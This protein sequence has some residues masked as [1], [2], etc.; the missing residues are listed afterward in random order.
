[1]LVAGAAASGCAV[2]PQAAGAQQAATK[3]IGVLMGIAENDPEGRSRVDSPQGFDPAKTREAF[4]RL[5]ALIHQSLAA[6]GA[7]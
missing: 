4:D 2:R 6:G 7:K 5:T 3:R 1:M